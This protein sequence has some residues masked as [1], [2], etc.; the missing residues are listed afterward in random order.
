M[1]LSTNLPENG[2]VAHLRDVVAVDASDVQVGHSVEVIV[3]AAGLVAIRRLGIDAVGPRQVVLVVVRVVVVDALARSYVVTGTCVVV[4]PRSGCVIKPSDLHDGRDHHAE[5]G[6]QESPAHLLQ[7]GQRVSLL[8]EVRIEEAVEDWH[9]QQDGHCVEGV[10]GGHR[11][12]DAAHRQ[13]H[14]AA[15]VLEGRGHLRVDAPVRHHHQQERRE[16]RDQFHSID[17]E[18]GVGTS[19][20][21]L[22]LVEDVLAR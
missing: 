15:L 7:H 13:I 12:L 1:G 14:L 18:V 17:L 5:N 9:Q 6:A 4:I 11:Y 21:P 20:C 10:Q 16:A 8:L 19:V 2:Q 3:V 22:G